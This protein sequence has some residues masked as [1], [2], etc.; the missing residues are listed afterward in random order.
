MKKILAIVLA[1]GLCTGAFARDF[2][3]R[4][5][6][7]MGGSPFYCRPLSY[8]TFGFSDV[9]KGDSVMT[10]HTSFF[11]NPQ[12]G[13]NMLEFGVR[14]GRYVKISLGAD[15]N[16]TWYHLDKEYMWVPIGTNKVEIVN[17]NL[18]GIQTV[19]QSVF[20]TPTFEFPLNVYFKTGRVGL[21]L[22]A[23][24]EVRTHAFCEFKGVNN[25]DRTVN[26]MRGGDFYSKNI[27]T[28]TLGYNLHVA[29]CFRG[30][31]V[32]AKFRPA[33]IIADGCGPQFSTWTVG[34]IMGM[35]L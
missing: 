23:A 15:V 6:M 12:L 20:T 18:V 3:N 31:G 13:F 4:F 27:R 11:K 25:M 35:V 28:N 21:Q 29:L 24:L 26:D 2:G 19:K 17:K 34:L 14:A 33:P 5:D 9:L 8:L 7:G 30:G 16:W 32:F 1:L 10:E 22:G